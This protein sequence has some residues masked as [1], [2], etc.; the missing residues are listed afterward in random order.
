M[1]GEECS[2]CFVNILHHVLRRMPSESFIAFSDIQ[3]ALFLRD[4]QSKI[5]RL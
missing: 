3:L 5:L 1:H 2:E 4:S